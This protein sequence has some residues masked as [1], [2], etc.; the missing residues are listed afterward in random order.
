[1][2]E[3][4]KNA[5]MG[6][7]NY[8]DH[9]KLAFLL[10]AVLLF[11]WF[12]KKKVEQ[13]TFLLY[14]TV[15]TVCCI[16]PPAAA[17]LMAYQTKFYDYQWIWSMVPLTAVISW[18]MVLILWEFW[19][20]FGWKNR[21]KGLPA[22]ILLLAVVCLCGSLGSR[23][24][25]MDGQKTDRQRA[26]RVLKTVLAVCGTDDICLWAP[27][28]VMAY[29]REAQGTVRLPYGR[30]MWDI[31]LGAYAYDTYDEDRTKM[32][33]WMEAVAGN[34]EDVRSADITPKACAE[35]A[36]QAGVTCILLPEDA[37]EETVR[38]LGEALGTDAQ[39]LED[40]WIFYGWTD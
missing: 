9:G 40:Y 17:V 8:N 30:D 23:V 16:L 34:S 13:K 4:L 1:M 21:R 38:A 20:D 6:W 10:L 11:C 33:Q 26:H 15:M 5:W 32:Y 2:R 28:E 31:S 37:A 14:T 12:G 18:G 19:P 22:A 39:K 27:R 24:W 36:A 7:A 25:D 29:V 35:Y 3:L